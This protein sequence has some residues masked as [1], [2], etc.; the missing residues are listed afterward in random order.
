MPKTDM[1]T[2]YRIKK[3]RACYPKG[4]EVNKNC[5]EVA[6]KREREKRRLSGQLLKG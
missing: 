6:T 2:K 5:E 4:E 3:T 1:E